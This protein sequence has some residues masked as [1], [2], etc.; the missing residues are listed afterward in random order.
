MNKNTTV[1]VHDVRTFI[2]S[3]PIKKTDY[4][5]RIALRNQNIGWNK[6]RLELLKRL[7]EIVKSHDE[8]Y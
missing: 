2:Q 3:L 7:G 4:R 6:C 8:E 5:W 1:L